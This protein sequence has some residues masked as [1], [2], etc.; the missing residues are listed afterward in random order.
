M[1][2]RSSGIGAT[3][4]SLRGL[5]SE[6][7]KVGRLGGER[8]GFGSRISDVLTMLPGR[9]GTR[10]LG[11]RNAVRWYCVSGAVGQSSWDYEPLAQ[12]EDATVGVHAVNVDALKGVPDTYRSTRVLTLSG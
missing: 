7:P 8:S 3:N 5:V 4:S 12:R 10:R 6:E 1:L 2:F 9:C 11:R